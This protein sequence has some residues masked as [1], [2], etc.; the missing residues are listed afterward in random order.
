MATGRLFFTASDTNAATLQVAAMHDGGV[1]TNRLTLDF[2]G[3]T[4]D[5][6]TTGNT[7]V[8]GN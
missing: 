3:V 8:A 6:T 2:S 7:F 5:P 4:D 1:P